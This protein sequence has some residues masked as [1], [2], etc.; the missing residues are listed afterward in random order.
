MSSSDMELASQGRRLA[1]FV[2]RLLSI[3]AYAR[4][5]LG[6]MVPDRGARRTDPAEAAPA[7]AR[8]PWGWS[9]GRP[10]LDADQGPGRA[11]HRFRRG[12]WGIGGC[13]GRA[14]GRGHLHAYLRR[15]GALVRLGRRPPMPLG[16]DRAHACRQRPQPIVPLARNVHSQG[17]LQLQRCSFSGGSKVWP[18][19]V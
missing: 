10:R 12:Q 1:G 2:L 7:Y 14:G 13:A 6:H 5:R 3:R 9:I 11:M 8:H 18:G 15:C 16:Q 17:A 4:H 19:G